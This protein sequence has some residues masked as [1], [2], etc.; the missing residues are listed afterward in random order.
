MCPGPV[1]GAAGGRLPSRAPRWL[2]P[3]PPLASPPPLPAAGPGCVSR[4]GSSFMGTAIYLFVLGARAGFLSRGSGRVREREGRAPART[5]SR[6][7]FAAGLK[8]WSGS[9]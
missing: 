5:L 2:T 4:R 8:S 3:I 6:R 7:R 9:D 1:A